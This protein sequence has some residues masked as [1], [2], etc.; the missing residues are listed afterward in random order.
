MQGP[1]SGFRI[2]DSEWQPGIGTRPFSTPWKNFR[3]VFHAME[4]FCPPVEK[5]STG[6]WNRGGAL[7]GFRGTSKRF[8]DERNH[9][10]GT[11]Q[12]NPEYQSMKLTPS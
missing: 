11:V 9:A 2:Q 1:N 12:R 10:D 5:L 3:R 7:G 6:G 8:A 4:E